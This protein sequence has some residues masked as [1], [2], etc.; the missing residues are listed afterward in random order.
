[1]L[2][3]AIHL[4][5]PVSIF[6]AV[7]HRFAG[8]R[9]VLIVNVRYLLEPVYVFAGTSFSFCYNLFL[10]ATIEPIRVSLQSYFAGTNVFFAGTSN[11]FCYNQPPKFSLLRLILLEPVCF[12]LEPYN[13][14][15]SNRPL[16]ILLV[17]AGHRLPRRAGG[18]PRRT[19]GGA[20]LGMLQPW[21]P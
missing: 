8:T 5:E 18:G 16:R 15:A 9:C 3:P 12:L 1:M 4:L 20:T 14:F 10:F 11:F 6:A 19:G 7:G 2:Q 17:F 13:E 21:H